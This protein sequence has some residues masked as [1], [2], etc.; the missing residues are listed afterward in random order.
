MEAIVKGIL[1]G[2]GY[3]LLIGPL[4]FMNIRLT[5]AYGFRH[6]LALVAG[7]FTSDLFLVLT[8]WWGASMLTT[9]ASDASFKRWFGLLC[10]LLLL[11]FG[12]SAV[13]SKKRDFAKEMDVTILPARRHYSYLQGL[14]VN[15]TNPS[16]WLFWLSVATVA[17]SEAPAG[18]LTY[19]KVFMAFAL[20]TLF[21]TDLCK[22][23]LAHKIGGWLKPGVPE[24]IVRVAGV[25]LIILSA[26]VLFTVFQNSF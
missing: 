11:G 20:L 25:I 22:V 10:G 24:K 14:L 26:W 7:A 18:N 23:L 6:G 21:A 12:I 16:N 15:S 4:F 5:L 2:L 3:G 9:M 13:W 19:A 17:K 8:S 1:S